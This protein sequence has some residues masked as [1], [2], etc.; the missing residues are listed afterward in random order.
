MAIVCYA[1]LLCA[2]IVDLF[3]PQ[4]FVV[5]ILFNAPI[6]LSSL[7]LSR[8][9]TAQ[10]VIAAQIANIIAGY[11][12]G[13]QNQH[14]W[15]G[16][17]IGDRVL[18]ALS[19]VLV[20]Y[21]SVKT[22][23]YARE[24]GESS[25]R[26][27]QVEIE[28]ALRAAIDRVRGSLNVELVLRGVL[29]E[30]TALVTASHG[31]LIVRG[32]P[33]DVPLVLSC[34]R[35]GADVTYAR[36][37]P[38]AEISSLAERARE[39]SEAILV[40]PADALARLTLDALEAGEALA[41]ALHGEEP[42]PVLILAVEAGSKVLAG[43]ADILRAFAGQAGIALQQARLFTRLGE[44]HDEIV[45]QRDEIARSGNVIRD[46]VYA[47]AHDL[48]TPLGASNVTMKQALSGAYGELPE[49]Y[50]EVLG[51]ALASNSEERRL[52]ETLLL[53]ARYE[54]GEESN[55]RESVECNDVALRTVDD[56]GQVAEAKG[57]ALAA[58]VAPEPLPVLGD[59]H[60][61]RR[62]IVNL[63]ANAL[64]AT[65][66]GGSVTIRCERRGERVAFIVDDTGYGIP[67]ERHSNLFQRF[68]GAGIGAGTGLGLYIVRRI[69][70]KHGGRI[71]YAARDL[72][73]SEFTLELP[74]RGEAPA[75]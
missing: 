58:H 35:D 53:V 64:A 73:G 60:E 13:V 19:F 68:G 39:S 75:S 34:A 40:R 20:G 32:S 59:V 41:V 11:V 12:N 7:A 26:A 27:R 10:L 57:V 2:W 6:A 9:L 72:G 8:G 38:A 62:A 65:P 14:H 74:L 45:R 1:L 18:S 43:A 36:K 3:T 48:R 61:L 17:A 42:A 54:S 71:T 33:L 67:P 15:D 21:L 47:L 56:L 37:A 28:K 24:A 70:E 55:V 23:D 5:S 69:A 30:A 63:T 52:V 4:L 31:M 66:Q 49:R 51:T 16:I 50:R 46:I 44:Q 29:R 22:Q 25:F